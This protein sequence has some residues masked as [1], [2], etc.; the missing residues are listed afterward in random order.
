MT[1]WVDRD[2][3]ENLVNEMQAA[4]DL[5]DY[6]DADNVRFEISQDAVVVRAAYTAEDDDE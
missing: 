4:L 6:T 1:Y 5:A 2:E 3:L